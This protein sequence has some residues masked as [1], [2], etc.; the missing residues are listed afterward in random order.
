MGWQLA[1]YVTSIALTR[2]APARNAP[3][4]ILS[5]H[6]ENWTPPSHNLP[7]PATPRRWHVQRSGGT[8]KNASQ[9]MP[10]RWAV[11][12]RCSCVRFLTDV[13][14]CLADTGAME[15]EPPP[16]DG[17]ADELVLYSYDGP[18]PSA[19]RVGE[20]ERRGLRISW[21]GGVVRRVVRR[22]D[23]QAPDPSSEPPDTTG[24]PT[25]SID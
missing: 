10:P 24:T 20:A 22:G 4:A 8:R 6:H 12:G 7:T 1:A 13:T 23:V 3:A 5:E 19:E 9:R 14:R 15:N 25:D 18:Q 21:K 17:I 11:S 16:E 2:R